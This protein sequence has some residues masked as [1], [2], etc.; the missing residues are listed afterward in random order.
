[1]AAKNARPVIRFA[2]FERLRQ[3]SRSALVLDDP[4]PFE[5]GVAKRED[6][7]KG[8]LTHDLTNVRDFLAER[9]RKDVGCNV[10]FSF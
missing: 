3:A 2:L 6:G 9:A 1:M 8:L 4:T 7:I 10:W 5:G